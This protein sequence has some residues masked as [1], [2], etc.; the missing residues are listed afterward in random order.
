[1]NPGYLSAWESGSVYDSPRRAPCATIQALLCIVVVDDTRT[2]QEGETRM[3][4]LTRVGVL[5]LAKLQ[6]VVM[7]VAGLIAG[8][9]YSF[10]GA[11]YELF[12]GTLNAG[13]ILAFGALVGMPIIFGAVGLVAGA[14][15]AV[16]YNFAAKRF[17]GIELDVE[18]GA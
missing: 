3:A 11:L 17:G 7:V 5:F 8:I 9:V 10:G 15:G 13:T 14:V 1:M 4:K 12:T 18:Q 16:L 6:A 2:F